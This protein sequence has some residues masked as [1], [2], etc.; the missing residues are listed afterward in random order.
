M[1][2]ERLRVV[3]VLA[4][5]CGTTLPGAAEIPTAVPARALVTR[6]LQV[7]LSHPEKG[8]TVRYTTDGTIP[9]ATHGWD[10]SGQLALSNTTIL[11]AVA[12]RGGEAVSEVVTHSYLRLDQVSSQTGASLPPQWG[13]RDGKPVTAHYVVN[14]ELALRHPDSADL[15]QGLRD[16]PTLSIVC[17]PDDLFG[18]QTGIYCHPM[19]HGQPW[20]RACSL[21]WFPTNGGGA[22]QINAGIRIQGGWNRR[23]EESP[24]HAF[25]IVFKKEHGP[26]AW[27][28]DLFGAGGPTEFNALILR[29]GCNNTWLHWSGEERRRGDYIRDQWMRDSYAAMGHAS[30]RG[31]FAHLYLNGVYWGVY[32][33]VER[34]DAAFAASRFGGKKSEYDSRN[35]ENLL[36]GDDKAWKALFAAANGPPGLQAWNQI[37][38]LL[39]LGSFADF[40]LLNYY[41]ANGDWDRSSNWYAA[42][43]RTPAGK[44]VFFV[45]DGERTL[46]KPEEDTLAFDDD[47]SPSRLFHRLALHNDFKRLFSDRVQ[48]HLLQA[49]GALHPRNASARYR[50]W[51]D[52]LR[53]PIV[54]ESARWGSYRR[55]LHSYKTGPY[56]QYARS[57]H[58][59]PEVQR[60][61]NRYFPARTD[62]FLGQLRAA[63]L[64]TEPARPEREKSAGEK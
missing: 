28:Y 19:E 42:R 47:E 55:D 4:F 60:L 12:L 33:V 29:A 36:S 58:W 25:R 32:N 62:A 49:D 18:P 23:P 39:D 26:S 61:L 56:E 63:G 38:N 52:L 54:A 21:E 43:R 5:A 27:R 64:L 37:T 30:A 53:R 7:T 15:L 35:G 48:R 59:E 14:G 24:K 40:M 44:F 6:D 34:P 9:S 45:W 22:V 13:E 16:L 57:S 41:G 2:R 46:E 17:R 50:A 3:F 20:E 31:V 51:S 10:F 11:R 1:A 8:T